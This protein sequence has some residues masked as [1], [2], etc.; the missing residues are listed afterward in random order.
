M[1]PS[2]DS[3]LERPPGFAARHP[4]IL[5]ALL[6]LVL[7]AALLPFVGTGFGL[8]PEAGYLLAGVTQIGYLVPAAILLMKLGR[9]EVV[10]GMLFAAL[11]TFIVNAAG[12]A[13]LLHQLSHIV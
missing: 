5:G 9:S 13:V 6:L 2:V 8:K 11:A 1:T 10:K 7:H 3:A 12:C 4:R